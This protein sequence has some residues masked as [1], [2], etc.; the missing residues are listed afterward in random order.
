MIHTRQG[1]IAPFAAGDDNPFYLL[2]DGV[3]LP[4]AVKRGVSEAVAFRDG[5]ELAA[6]PEMR[7]GY[8]FDP[9]SRVWVGGAEDGADAVA[10][11]AASA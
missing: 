8:L 9:V 6:T 10:R 4:M 5:W 7:R 3:P 11:A 1:D 2:C